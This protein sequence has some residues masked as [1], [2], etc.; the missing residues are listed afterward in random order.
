MYRPKKIVSGCDI[1]AAVPIPIG[2]GEAAIFTSKLIHGGGANHTQGTRVSVDFAV[3]PSAH[4][5]SQHNFQLA[6]HYQDT[7]QGEKYVPIRKKIDSSDL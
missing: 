7:R 1:G 5:Q 6:A 4:V 3:I 2:V